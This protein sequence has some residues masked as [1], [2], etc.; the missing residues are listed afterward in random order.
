[1]T[2]T[3]ATELLPENEY[4]L[5]DT[6]IG[7]RLDE[8]TRNPESDQWTIEASFYSDRLSI[9]TPNPAQ[10]LT[11]LVGDP[12]HQRDRF[13]GLRIG[14][15]VRRGKGKLLWRITGLS[16]SAH[17]APVISLLSMPTGTGTS[18]LA[19]S[20]QSFAVVGAEAIAALTKVEQ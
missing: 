11:E 6:G 12:G 10:W 5:L 16:A 15:L 3:E 20:P 9:R 1:M 18:G 7:L 17:H 8:I 14:D 19:L 4:F 2:T 13:A